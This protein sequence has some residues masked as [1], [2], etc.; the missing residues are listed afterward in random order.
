M[1][2]GICVMF[3]VSSFAVDTHDH[4]SISVIFNDETVFNESEQIAITEKIVN[5]TDDG[6]DTC[7][8]LCTLLGH[9]LKS[10]SVGAI[11]HKVDDLSPRCLRKTYSVTTCSRC[12]YTDIE[13]LY[14]IYVECCPEE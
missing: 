9:D 4:N 2:L 11:E 14:D 12:D 10:E 1:I 7:G 8:I 6:I 5:D 13:L 3:S